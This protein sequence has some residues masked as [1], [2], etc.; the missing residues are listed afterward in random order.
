MRL[1]RRHWRKIGAGLA[2]LAALAA[3][4]LTFPPDLA[5]AQL[6]S[7]VV[8]D[9]DGRILHP[10][11]AADGRWRLPAEPAEVDARYLTLLKA[12]EDQRF[13]SH[14]GVDLLAVLRAG[15]QL[16]TSGHIVSGASTL[17]M[18]TARLLNP[19]HTRGLGAKA[20]QALRALQL[21]RR[22]SKERILQIYLALAPFG[23]NLEGVRAASLAYFGKEPAQLTLGQAA[24]LVALPQSPE[25][26]RPD[27]HPDA[28]KGGRDKVLRLL[29]ERGA[30]SAKARDEALGEPV[31]TARRPMPTRAPHL[32][33]ALAAAA[34]RGHVIHTEIAGT[35][36]DTLESL[37]RREQA[38]LDDGRGSTNL[39]FIVVENDSRAVRAYVGNAN[40]RGRA[41]FIDLA[42]AI[43]S[44]GSTLKPFVYAIGFDDLVAHPLT[45]IEDRPTL[46]GDY[47]PRNFDR[48]YQGTVTFADALRYSLNVP[49]VALL[50]RIGPARF[51]AKLANAGIPLTFPK[52][53]AGPSLPL[54]LGGVGTTLAD[55]V[56]LYASLSDDGIVRPLNIRHDRPARARAVPL[57]GPA[58]AWYVRD[59]LIDNPLPE[60]W[61]EGRGLM[62]RP[63]A[64]K[65]GTSYGFRDA[66]SIGVSGRYTVGVWVGRP[67]GSTRPGAI[68]RNTAAPLLLSIFDLLPPEA[69]ARPAP[70]K[71]AIV[72]HNNEELPRAL[73]RFAVNRAAGSG[74]RA[75]AQ[76]LEIAFPPNGATVALPDSGTD[77]SLRAEGG[78]GTLFWVVDG[79]PLDRTA[80][81]SRRASWAP[82]GPGYARVTVIDQT[83]KSASSIVKLVSAP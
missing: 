83:G 54:V 64:F 56:T 70:P 76:P 13:D 46:F 9:A 59:V 28:A 47:E 40:P 14:P 43:R 33:V 75:P 37:A 48:G 4:D 38:A 7:T 26:L 68:G 39:A 1:L 82:Q 16:V 67:D 80:T 36:Q 30:I 50:D 15:G 42:R 17:T 35:L 61:G 2:A 74:A 73:R 72:A 63:I 18:Q 23:G 49:A 32:A 55:L 52:G 57:F 58:A 12:Y 45:Q 65:T 19:G 11:L 22:F 21:E 81:E 79:T 25:R 5:R 60:G 3:L 71:G 24:L 31:P 34:P 51:A 53:V 66:W 8:T 44:P 6:L 41:G 20:A 62:R 69:A 29:A 77:L 78:H 10:F 27:R